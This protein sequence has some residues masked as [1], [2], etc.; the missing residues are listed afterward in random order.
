MRWHS[1]RTWIE[2][3]YVVQYL[4]SYSAH[5]NK[6][7]TCLLL[8]ASLFEYELAGF[9]ICL[10]KV[11]TVWNDNWFWFHSQPLF[12]Q[13]RPTIGDRVGPTLNLIKTVDKPA[14]RIR[15][16]PF[17]GGW[18]IVVD[19]QRGWGQ[20]REEGQSKVHQPVRKQAT[21]WQR[22]G[23]R[24]KIARRLDEL[25]ATFFGSMVW[26][27]QS[28]LEN[29]LWGVKTPDAECLVCNKKYNANS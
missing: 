19:W 24:G 26:F 4:T 23:R 13:C 17:L 21:L 16:P 10:K 14:T 8:Q 5:G 27:G 25:G 9:W 22:G 28:R 12:E 15:P 20:A 7:F 11:A 2:L 18:L 3:K 1:L 29:M 6:Q